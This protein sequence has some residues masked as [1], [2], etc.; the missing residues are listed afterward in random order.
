MKT[1][2]AISRAL[3]VLSILAA[4]FGIST[5]QAQDQGTLQLQAVAE[6]EIVQ[7]NPDGTSSVRR[8]PAETV[9]P[10]DDVI[11]TLLYNNQGTAAADDVFITNPI[12]EHMELRH[13]AEN[14]A[15]LETLYSV[16]G[17]QTF[18]PLS[19]LTLT[20]GAGQTR[21]STPKDCTHIRWQFHRSLAPG[22]SGQV[23]YTTRLL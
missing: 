19:E 9:V 20:D 16:D 8:V 2:R 13:A 14:P 18:G 3:I 21:R 5:A 10:G 17:G 6:M 11:Y 7:E 15:W 4:L 1:Q 12:P 23:S 22:E